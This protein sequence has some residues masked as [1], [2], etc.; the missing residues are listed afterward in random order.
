MK[1]NL[2]RNFKLNILVVM[3]A[4]SAFAANKTVEEPILQAAAQVTPK[5]Y[6][7]DARGLFGS[8]NKDINLSNF[9]SNDAI[10]AGI[11]SLNTTVNE[12]SLGQLTLAFDHLDSSAGAVLCID[13]A[14]LEQLD[15]R[16]DVLSSL[17]DQKCLT[18]KDLSPDAY[19]DYD[20]ASLSLNISL[21]LNITNNRPAGYIAPSRFD[22]GVTAA[23]LNYDFNMYQNNIDRK[24]DLNESQN[25]QT[26]YLSLAG[27]INFAGF[28]FRHAG[29]FQ[30]DE[31]SGLGSYQSY[32]N[33][34]STDIVP[35]QSR[36]MLGDF[37]TLTYNL[38]SAQ[39]R[40]VQLASEGNMRPMSQRSYAPM[41]RGMANTNA[42][43]TIFQNGRKVYERT[44]PAGGFEINDLTAISNNGDLTVQVTENGGEKHSF[45]VPM[46]GSFNLLRVGQFNYSVAAGQYKLNHKTL[47][48]IVTQASFEYGLNNYLS[49]YTGTN[50]SN[51]YKSYLFGIGSNTFLGG[52]TADVEY[53]KAQLQG[54]D[55][56]GQK[57]KLGY[58]YNIAALGTTFNLN[59]LYQSQDFMTLGNTMSMNNIDNLNHAEMDNFL[60]T[61]R[62]KQQFNLSLYQNLFEARYGSVFLSAS[63]NKYWNNSKNFNQY[64]IGYSN[65]WNRLQYSVGFNQSNNFQNETVKDRRVY[66]SLSMPLD[67]KR[68]R[69]QLNSNIQHSR[70]SFNQTTANVGFSGT[71][72]ENNQM[73]YGVS[74]INQTGDQPSSS[75]LSANLN[76]RLPQVNLGVVSS[77]NRDYQQYG[78]SARGA[79]VA[80]PH[81]ITATNE[82]SETFTIIH[83]KAA[84]GADVINAW[85]VKLDRF[86]NAIY[87][88]LT[89]YDINSI[90]LDTKNLPIELH[91]DANQTQV[92]PRLFSST[93]VEFKTRQTSNILLNV[94]LSQ[95]RKIPIGSIATDADGKALGMFGQSNQLFIEDAQGLKNNLLVTWGSTETSSCRIDAPTQSQAQKAGVFQVID[96]ECK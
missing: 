6:G 1:V 12:T 44:V 82:Q 24:N 53:S 17:V 40:G 15:L 62:L 19:Y 83:A 51:P 84:K 5:L 74:A 76:Y 10:A 96:V 41:I 60:R 11:Y 90:G 77:L 49:T 25:T 34:I 89:A 86:G 93:L 85:G 7:F 54:E 36:L 38:D 28:N 32:L 21:P 68:S 16:K 20:R 65:Y 30:S 73:N 72:G 56:A 4:Q 58:Q 80:H 92:I 8:S 18:I 9:T 70:S 81:G 33:A 45:I 79:V 78:I 3:C 22:K 2:K 91:I 63:Q 69:V 42:L 66:L 14:L 23:Y 75:T 47:D 50:L 67:W 27:G 29:S 87:P 88:N 59:T 61:F 95:N 52:I 46:Q 35:I 43:V 55:Y 31:S 71:Y 13:S 39:I 37:N 64:D 26:N 94:Q 48:D 57:Y